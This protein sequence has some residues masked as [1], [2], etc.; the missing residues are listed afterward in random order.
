MPA[1]FRKERITSRLV[2]ALKPGETV[3]D[4]NLSG[5]CVRRQQDA[6]VYFVRKHAK[7]K[8]HYV[9]IGEH[10]RERWTEAKA[11]AAALEMIAALRQG[12]DPAAERAHAKGMPTLAAFAED[13]I[14]QRT[15]TLK[16]GTI[17]NYKGLLNKHVAPLDENGRLKPERLGKLKLDQINHPQIAAVHRALKATPRAANHMLAFLSSVYSEAQAAGL[18]PEG[19]NPT[20]RV[21]RFSVKPRQRFL[22]EEELAHVGDVLAEVEADGLEDPYA[23]AA[24]RLLIFTG[25]RRDEILTGRWDWVDFE[26]GLMNLPDSKTGAKTVYLS[27]PA[28]EVLKRLARVVGNPHIIVGSKEGQRWVNLRKV[29]VRVR[30]R[31]GL[32]PTVLS[33]G[34]V[35]E[36]RLHD[37]RHS[38]ASLAIDGG[39]S[40]PIIGKLLGHSQVQTTSRYAHLADHPLRRV[41][42][43]VGRRAAAAMR[44]NRTHEM[45]ADRPRAAGRLKSTAEGAQ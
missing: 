1:A 41:N 23:I 29:W 30:S 17:A 7:D 24:L 38:Y 4:I 15:A 35:Q 31:A 16:P 25:C 32:K 19:H 36:V 43:E 5:Y 40:L 37:L 42:D 18:V 27:P 45:G 8:R 33:N 39:A 34:K 44:S 21:Q 2:E 13:F 11:R 12:K 28:L 6:R 22:T 3:A 14:A 20:R 26:R 10:G 9:T